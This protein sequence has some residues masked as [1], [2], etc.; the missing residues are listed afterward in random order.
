MFYINIS[1]YNIFRNFR[2]FEYRKIFKEVF[3]KLYNLFNTL[4]DD[5]KEITKNLII[6]Y[7]APSIQDENNFDKDNFIINVRL[8]TI[9]PK[10]VNYISDCDVRTYEEDYADINSDVFDSYYG[11]NLK[12]VLNESISYIENYFYNEIVEYSMTEE[13]VYENL[14]YTYTFLGKQSV[15]ITDATEKK[16]YNDLLKEW[17]SENAYTLKFDIK[18]FIKNKPASER[19]TLLISI[20]KK[21]RSEYSLKNYSEYIRNN[22]FKETLDNV[23]PIFQV[24]VSLEEK[25]YD[26]DD[27]EFKQMIYDKIMED[28]SFT[29]YI[30]DFDNKLVGIN[31]ESPLENL[32]K[33]YDYEQ[34][35]NNGD[36]DK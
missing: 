13:K 27:E 6:K 18:S 2:S 4:S 17:F 21:I 8:E 20:L 14:L 31:Y 35:P 5:K 33:F 25:D 7:F 34:L 30:K 10:L 12:P 23:L 26:I 22:V 28:F 29:I 36:L 16:N 24:S 11:N 3:E 1:R 15:Y 19:A 9:I 32:D